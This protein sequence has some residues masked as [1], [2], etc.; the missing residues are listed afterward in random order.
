MNDVVDCDQVK[1][2]GNTVKVVTGHVV[3]V[4]HAVRLLHRVRHR[5]GTFLQSVGHSEY[6]H[7]M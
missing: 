5:G 1:V 4:Q 6:F 3:P 7:S 2:P